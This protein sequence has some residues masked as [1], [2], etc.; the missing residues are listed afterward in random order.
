MRRVGQ[1]R[2]TSSGLGMRGGVIHGARES[3]RTLHRIT[4]RVFES[5]AWSL[6][7]FKRG[8]G[9]VLSTRRSVMMED[10]GDVTTEGHASCPQVPL[11]YMWRGAPIV[12]T[13]R[14]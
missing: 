2:V 5:S 9:R 7:Q 3:H 4:V 13:T 14:T 11:E 6:G 1:E 12:D 8:T 10:K